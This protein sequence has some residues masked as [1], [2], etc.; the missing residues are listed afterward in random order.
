MVRINKIFGKRIYLR[1]ITLDDISLEYCSWLADPKVNKHLRVREHTMD[2]LRIYV[3]DQINDP[4]TIFLG[5][6]DKTNNKH[7]GNI[8]LWSIDW[9]KKKAILSILIGNRNYWGKGIGAEAI[10]LTLDFVFNSLG[11]NEVELGVRAKNKRATKSFKECGFKIM[12]IK[13]NFRKCNGILYD[14]VVMKIKKSDYL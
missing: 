3:Q 1:E 5:I 2:E 12:E 4:E 7:V 8:R 6:F 14:K 13:K 11:F 10:K 9:K